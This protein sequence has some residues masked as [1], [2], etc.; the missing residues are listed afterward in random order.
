MN[1]IPT[2]EEINLLKEY[3]KTST[4]FEELAVSDSFSRYIE[5]VDKWVSGQADG[6]VATS[7]GLTAEQVKDKLTYLRGLRDGCRML[8]DTTAFLKDQARAIVEQQ[9]TD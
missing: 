1:Q 5:E 6:L 2:T 4:W 3:L 9:S 8:Y 7:A